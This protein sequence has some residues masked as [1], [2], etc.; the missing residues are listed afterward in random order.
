[1]SQEVMFR[2]EVTAAQVFRRTWWCVMGDERR[3]SRQMKQRKLSSLWEMP[4]RSQEGQPVPWG[5]VL[6]CV[7]A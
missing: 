1:M 3:K 5:E 4:L 2:Q 7:F 6:S